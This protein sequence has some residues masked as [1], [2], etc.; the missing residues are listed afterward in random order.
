M[1]TRTDSDRSELLTLPELNRRYGVGL[2][3]LRRAATQGAF[4]LYSAGTAWPRVRLAD[5]ERWLES[6][7]LTMERRP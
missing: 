4:P 1:L 2:H 7:C 6:T 3:S 5:F